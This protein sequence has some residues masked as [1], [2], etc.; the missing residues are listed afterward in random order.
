MSV[1][2]CANIVAKGDPDRFRATMAAPLRAREV[3]FPLYA[4]NVEV[5]RAPWLTAEPMI[6]EMRLQWWRDALGEIANAGP[7]RKHEVTTPL[8]AI[9]SNDDA[10][11]LDATIA[12]RRWDIYRDPF[13]DEAHMLSYL[14]AT[15]GGLMWTAVR[16][17]GGPAEAK[18][19]VRRFGRATALA[20]FLAAVPELKARG[21]VPLRDEEPTAIAK[22]VRQCLQDCP[23]VSA[24]R[25]AVGPAARP[26]LTEG[27][28]TMAMLTRIL[29]DPTRVAEGRVAQSPFKKSLSLFLS[30][31]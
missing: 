28:E 24:L 25:D 11:R 1:Q 27:W 14:D 30:R 20:R 17:L 8:S 18:D 22:L 15:G 29:K 5:A 10:Q 26:A 7:V 19:M 9:L 21:R 13:E 16:C 4:F 6:A 23:P 12:A 3:L 2:A 31:V